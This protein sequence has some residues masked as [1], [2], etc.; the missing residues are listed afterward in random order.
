MKHKSFIAAISLLICV[1]AS[2]QEAL[3]YAALVSSPKVNKDSTV[4]LS[5]HAPKAHKVTVNGFSNKAIDLTIDSSGV[6]NVT[7]PKLSPDFYTYTFDVDGVRVIDPSNAYTTR[8]IAGV[9]STVIVPGGNADLYLTRNVPHGTIS[10]L[11]YDSPELNM[12]RRMTI[13]TPPGYEDDQKSYPVLYLLHGMGG[14]EDAWS[15]L[16][17]A[18]QIL[19]NLIAAGKAEPMIVVMPNG[20]SRLAA[21]PGE[22]ALGMYTPAGEHSIGDQN[23]FELSIADIKNYVD[24]HYRTLPDKQHT[25][26]A[27]LS[28]GG[29]HAWRAS[30]LMPD[31]FGYVGLFSAAVRWNGNGISDSNQDY[32]PL[33]QHQFAN[34]PIL[35]WIG[36]GKDDFLYTLNADYISQL[37]SLGYPFEYHESA[38]GHTWS[39][40]RDY[41]IE[42]AGKIFK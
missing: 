1:N 2:A 10:K 25:A 16:G 31:M 37:K 17:R 34:P 4:T 29:G 7:T 22:S 36:I 18:T 20:N 32:L 24:K 15:S 40:W 41:L 42:F 3:S 6:W 14:D 39:N 26:I 12:T 23:K 33:L 13:Y 8:D 38:G 35:Y 30:M 21:A 28:M 19:D 11:W 27:G 5:L 9:F